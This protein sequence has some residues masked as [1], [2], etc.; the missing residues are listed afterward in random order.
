M[1]KFGGLAVEAAN[2]AM[3]EHQ[4]GHIDRADSLAREALKI[5]VRRED[6][7]MFP[8]LLSRL[9]AVA[10]A[11]DELV[12]G[13]TLIGAAETMMSTQG[14]AWPPD[15]RPHY[16]QTVTTLTASLGAKEFE[17]ASDEG[18][19]RSTKEAVRLALVTS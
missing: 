1:G 3:V 17:I 2:L 12:L 14:T 16:E 11:R 15:E 18:R 13:A 8:Y 19:S 6:E 10:T 5:A 9:A 4:L 7:W